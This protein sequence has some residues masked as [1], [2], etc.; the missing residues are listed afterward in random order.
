MQCR[1]QSCSLLVAL[2]SDAVV[3]VGVKLVDG[4]AHAIHHLDQWTHLVGQEVARL[5]GG[6]AVVQ[7][8]LKI[9]IP[10]LFD[11][12]VL[13]FNR[14]DHIL[15]IHQL[16]LHGVDEVGH[17]CFVRLGP[18]RQ[19]RLVKDVQAL[20]A[21]RWLAW[22]LLGREQLP[23]HRVTGLQARLCWAKHVA[24]LENA[25]FNLVD[26][27]V[28]QTV[29]CLDQTIHGGLIVHTQAQHVAHELNEPVEQCLLANLDAGHELLH[30]RVSQAPSQNF[31]GIFQR[32]DRAVVNLLFKLRQIASLLPLVELFDHRVADAVQVADQRMSWAQASSLS[33][34]GHVQHLMQHSDVPHARWIASLVVNNSSTIELQQHV[35][36]LV[37]GEGVGQRTARTVH[38]GRTT[39]AAQHLDLHVHATTL[40][41][42]DAGLNLL[43]NHLGK[44]VGGVVNDPLTHLVHALAGELPLHGLLFGIDGPALASIF[45]LDDLGRLFAVAALVSDGGLDLSWI[46]QNIAVSA[47]FKLIGVNNAVITKLRNKVV[48]QIAAFAIFPFRDI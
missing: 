42:F 10:L 27:H 32:V 18:L 46:E 26:R 9:R 8:F 6:A 36:R 22:R 37:L 17:L 33:N 45:G 15:R 19:R 38:A 28:Q 31:I 39:V 16:V 3:Q 13:I 40:H 47:S 20:L 1:I 29:R 14:L 41:L 30:V 24:L 34:R 21:S 23:L 4:H 11:L 48:K 44:L 35:S 12:A 25:A 5:F 2:L 7:L 43:S